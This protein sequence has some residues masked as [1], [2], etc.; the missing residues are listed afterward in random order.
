MCGCQWWPLQLARIAA[1][2]QDDQL[3]IIDA[4][5]WNLSDYDTGFMVSKFK[6]DHI[7]VATGNT[8]ISIDSIFQEKMYHAFKIRCD[9][10]SN[11][12]IHH[13]YPLVPGRFLSKYLDELIPIEHKPAYVAPSEPYPFIDMVSSTGC[14]Y[15]K[16]TFCS[17]HGLPFSELPVSHVIEE[18]SYI[19]HNM[20][21]YKSIMLQDDNVSVKRALEISMGRIKEKLRL[22]WSCYARPIIPRKVLLVMKRSGCLNIHCGFESGNNSTLEK[23]QKGLNTETMREFM[24]DARYCGI[25]VHGDFI[26]SSEET[27]EEIENTIEYACDI[28]PHTAQFQAYVH[29]DGGQIE[30]VRKWQQK[31]YK[32]FYGNIR[33][34]G[35][36]IEQIGKPK[37]LKEAVKS[38]LK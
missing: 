19:E 13:M 17:S 4:Q 8:K 23:Y 14:S 38:C 36:I 3:T 2:H 37:I 11:A 33:S 18:M 21:P 30:D 25:K 9:S 35:R 7:I 32:R 27:P 1:H 22:P 12:E 31:A 15:G 28:K 34:F 6:P 5:A 20:M 26:I 24:N 16:C 10:M 29:Q